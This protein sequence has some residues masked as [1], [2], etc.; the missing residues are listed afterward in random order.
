[1]GLF[2]KALG[3]SSISL[4]GF[5]DLDGNGQITLNLDLDG[6]GLLESS[7]ELTIADGTNGVAV[8]NAALAL[9]DGALASGGASRALGNGTVAV[10]GAFDRNGNG[11]IE[12]AETTFADGV[13]AL[14]GETAINLF[15]RDMPRLSVDLDLVFLDHRLPREQ[16]LDAI[17][18]ALAS[19][20]ISGAH[21]N[22]LKNIDVEIPLGLMVCLTGVSGSGKSTLV[23]EVLYRNLKKLKESPSAKVTQCAA[24]SGADKISEVVLVDQS[25][26][27]TTP[28]SNPATYMKAFD[29]IRKLFAVTDLSRLRGYAPSTFSFNVE[30]GRCETCRGEGFEKVEMQFLSDVYT[31][32]PE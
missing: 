22:N 31:S 24:I 18:K 3:T 27:G 29:G 6:D 5:S 21:A 32:C 12:Q 28:R 4:G 14:K 16:A 9:G 11:I 15:V 25:P 17:G 7:S 13:F 8:G 10:G 1:M 26:V 19:I 23:D 20:K 30:G 2:S